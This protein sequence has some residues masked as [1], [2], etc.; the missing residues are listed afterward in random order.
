V[1]L[2]VGHEL[3]GTP[4]GILEGGLVSPNLVGLTVGITVGNGV[5]ATVGS[6]VGG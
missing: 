5:G 3:E 6:G 1:G 2:E 4:V